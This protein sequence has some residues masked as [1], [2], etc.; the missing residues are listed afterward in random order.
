MMEVTLDAT[1]VAPRLGLSPERFMALW[2]RGIIRQT[3]EQGVGDD[4][5]RSRVILR[6][7][8]VSVE[9][10]VDSDGIGPPAASCDGRK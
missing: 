6:Y 5:G 2:R 8:G 7:L 9:I 4:A 3:F 10:D 1:E